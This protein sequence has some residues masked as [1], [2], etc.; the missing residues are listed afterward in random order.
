MLVILDTLNRGIQD[1]NSNKEMVGYLN[2]CDSISKALDGCAVLIVHHTLH[3]T[4]RPRGHSSAMGNCSGLI[5]MEWN[6]PAVVATVTK[7]KDGRTG[8]QMASKTRQVM[9][10]HDRKGIPRTSVVLDA[11]EL[12]T[13]AAPARLTKGLATFKAA[14]RAAIEQWPVEHG[15]HK[16]TSLQDVRAKHKL[17]YEHNGKGD[18]D[19]AERV[20]WRRGLARAF[21]VNLIDRATVEVEGYATDILWLVS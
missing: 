6:A 16:V 4:D 9:L 1:E 18:A 11:A 7:M 8:E 13:K 2:A 14:V 5:S 3:D 21:A 15:E 19:K 20:A 17:L 12:P 10:P